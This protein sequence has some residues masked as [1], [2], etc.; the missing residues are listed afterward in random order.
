MP[1]LV[2][3]MCRCASYSSSNAHKLMKAI[4]TKLLLP[5]AG[6]LL[7]MSSCSNDKVD[8]FFKKFIQA[9]PSEIER[10]VKGHDQIYAVHA[11]LRM[12]YKGGTI[13]VGPNASEEVE[14]YNTY[15]VAGDETI[16][17]I[18]Q[19]IDIAKDDNGQMTITTK[20]DHFDVIASDKIY[21]GLELK[22][23]DQNGMLI[24]H[25]FSNF[26]FVKRKDGTVEP[27]EDNSALMMHQH[28][29]GVGHFTL[30]K[31]AKDTQKTLQLAYPRTL[32][33]T[34]HYIDRYTFLD[35]GGKVESATKFSASNI[36]VPEGF[37]LGS[38]SAVFD[39][40][41]SW[42]SI[43]ITGRPD[44][45]VPYRAPDGITYRLVRSIDMQRLNQLVPEIFSYEYRDTDPVEEELGKLFEE[46]YN[47]DYIDPETDSPRQRY[48]ETVGLLKQ[49]RS[50][51]AGAPL[52]R[53]GF[54]GVLQFKRAGMAFLLQVRLCNILT[55]GQ[56][57]TGD[58]PKPAKYTNINNAEKGYLWESNQIQ[59]GWDSFDIDYPLPIRVIA[60]AKDGEEK[61]YQDV[62]RFYPE[63]QRS[64]LWQMLTQPESF[65]YRYR[66]SIVR[67]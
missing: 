57:R 43:E 17:P 6:A 61:C 45:L 1:M 23:Y 4:Q 49:E 42:R 54:K 16:I 34:P 66:R 51:D 8:E 65:F 2:E 24:N 5:L 12:G 53:L 60:D 19:E 36:Y 25:Q 28:F 31:G 3:L 7:L 58:V 27:D 46:S 39:N 15:H 63:V 29:F 40:E 64:Q 44:A 26:P 52:D 67:M 18:V 21:Y 41:R 9:P 32:E 55:K 30:S 10:D 50:L 48:G 59:P 47:D 20:R 37:Q 56:Q 35:R 11:I 33:E 13:G 38:N 62:R 22:Y 14:T